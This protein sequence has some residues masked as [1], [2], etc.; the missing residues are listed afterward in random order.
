MAQDDSHIEQLKKALYS[1]NA[2]I[3][4]VQPGQLHPHSSLAQ[5]S[6]EKPV[7]DQYPKVEY[8][9][10]G[11]Y[12]PIL[13]KL[14][15]F[16]AFFFI[17]AVGVAGY[18]FYKGSNLISPNN[19]DITVSGPVT[20]PA[21]EE[22]SLDIDVKNTNNSDLNLADLIITYPD[23]TRST[24]DGV[25][26]MINARV[27]MGTI[28]SGETVRKTVKSILFGEENARKNIKVAVE[29]Q[30]PGS[31]TLFTKEKDYAIYIG[32]SPLA[33]T[34][35]G[36]KEVTANQDLTLKLNIVSNST[37]VVKDAVLKVDFP[38][39]FQYTSATPAQL[40]GNNF[41]A[42]GDVEPGGKRVIVIKG[43]MVGEENQSRVFKFYVGTA[44]TRNSSAIG[45]VFANV[46]SELAVTK[47][48]LGADVSLDGNSVPVYVA[49]A[50]NQI[51]GEIV[52]QNNLD[53]PINDAV[54]QVVATGDMLDKTSI[55][56]DQ[57]F[58]RSSNNTLIWDKTTLPALSQTNPGD[59]GR[60]QFSLGSLPPTQ[61]NN[62]LFRRPVINLVL[63]IKGKRLNEQK[64]S[65]E[66]TST[67]TRQVKI[68]SGLT[69]VTR[70]VRT[71]GP[72]QNTGPL[73]PV[74]DQKTTYTALVTIYNS[75]N[76]VR[77]AVF[78]TTLPNYVRW[79]GN[80]S[81]NTPGVNFNPDKQELTWPIGEIVA[82]TGYGTLPKQFA[83]QVELEPSVSQLGQSP[84]IVN[85]Q[86]IAGTDVF[87]DTVV[88]DVQDPLTIKI[89]GD[90]GYKYGDEKVVP[91]Q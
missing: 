10:K 40:S 67:V 25:S 20:A 27:P 32:N 65:E 7:D 8:G 46:S 52:W 12:N 22:L 21:G 18:I 28:K 16:A 83:F 26:S 87:A 72:F 66:I 2:H 74:P 63:N 71:I 57:G 86:R 36:L 60:V 75:Y 29:Y 70:L 80:I 77:D 23:G 88:E 79:M 48:F 13:Q 82:G 61:S 41:W 78:T 35:D 54:I 33:L 76:T 43:K 53:V 15:W 17:F 62:A 3:K 68:S 73:P 69:M 81:P 31:A 59:I 55:E 14:L 45:T 84:I 11:S 56:T 47:P 34:V 51:K 89:E 37:A 90:P 58:Y 9:Y 6:W 91:N 49:R 19:I 85:N 1:K 4:D 39:G 24:T 5:P 44:D 42:L 50:G 38:F 64:V 30:V